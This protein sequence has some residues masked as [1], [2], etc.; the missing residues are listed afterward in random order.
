MT[1][2]RTILRGLARFQAAWWDD[3]RLGVSSGSR[4]DAAAVG[5]GLGKCEEVLGRFRDRVGDILP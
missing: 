1:Q 3:P 5:S 2:C 4:G